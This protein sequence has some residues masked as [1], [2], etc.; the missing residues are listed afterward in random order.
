MLPKCY[1]FASHNTSIEQVRSGVFLQM[2]ELKLREVDR[3]EA[4]KAGV[5]TR[6]SGSKSHARSATS[7][8]SLTTPGF[9]SLTTGCWTR[10]AS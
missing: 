4:V 9:S 7:L 1:F 5:K 8:S 2:K 10:L 6:S 3:L